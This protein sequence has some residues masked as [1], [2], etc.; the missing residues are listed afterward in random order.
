MPT[1]TRLTGNFLPRRWRLLLAALLLGTP[2]AALAQF[3]GRVPPA[4]ETPGAL[5]AASG[6]RLLQLFREGQQTPPFACAFTLEQRPRRGPAR[7]TEGWLIADWRGDPYLTRV[8]WADPEQGPPLL[9]RNGR[10]PEA[11]T[12]AD[13]GAVKIDEAD[14]EAS[15]MDGSTITVFDLLMPYIHWDGTQ[16]L[17]PLRHLGRPAHAFRIDNPAAAGAVGR[18]ELLIDA[19]F[20]AP[21][22]VVTHDRSGE[23]LRTWSI[24]GVRRVDGLWTVHTLEVFD[25]ASRAKSRIVFSA[26]RDI[27]EPDVS[28]F[29]PAA[30][31]GATPPALRAELRAP[32]NDP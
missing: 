14:W 8:L 13:A 25:H 18:V 26:P 4:R 10:A 22:R 5:D 32:G 2:C 29:N 16:Y 6:T 11:W 12:V 23:R 17:G 21:L 3:K 7:T 24:S 15:L 27:G 31:A 30:L 20:F 19:D 9:L 1:A 28:W